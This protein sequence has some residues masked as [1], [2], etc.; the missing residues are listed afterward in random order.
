MRTKVTIIW[1]PQSETSAQDENRRGRVRAP[2][3]WAIYGGSD[4][5]PGGASWASHADA[6]DFDFIVYT[7]YIWANFWP[8]MC[9]HIRPQRWANR[10]KS[11]APNQ[12]RDKWASGITVIFSGH[13]V[14]NRDC[15][16]KSGTDGHL[17]A[18]GTDWPTDG[19][20]TVTLCFRLNAA[21]A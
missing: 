10:D 20:Q 15:S 18:D 14:K 11:R 21:A 6:G 4:L 7:D 16:G 5:G 8:P 13:V 17:N 3:A 19:R 12:N 9:K 1:A 2:Q